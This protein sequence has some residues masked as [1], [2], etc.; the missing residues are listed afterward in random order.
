MRQLSHQLHKLTARLDRA[1]DQILQVEVGTT[2]ARFLA[3]F[4]VSQ[5]AQSQRALATWLGI[6]EPSVSR[7]TG[8]L[9]E[10]GLLEVSAPPGGGNRRHLRLT[11]A[12][13]A[14]V[15]QGGRALERR[16]AHLVEAGGVDYEE[17]EAQT[18]R[19]IEQLESEG[20]GPLPEAGRE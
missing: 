15:K 18:V 9:V 4:A 2:Y 10:A 7:M 17:F 19:V 8:V 14:L 16:F 11:E 3:L 5:G 13:A 6:T 1:A 12:G 20:I